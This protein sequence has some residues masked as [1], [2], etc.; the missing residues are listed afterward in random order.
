MEGA[1]EVRMEA[2]PVASLQTLEKQFMAQL[3]HK[4]AETWNY[5]GDPPDK[6]CAGCLHAIVWHRA[7][8]PLEH[9]ARLLLIRSLGRSWSFVP[10]PQLLGRAVGLL[11]RVQ[12]ATPG[13]LHLFT[14]VFAW[15]SPS[16]TV[17]SL[18][19]D[20]ALLHHGY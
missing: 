17:S 18:A 14:V 15:T 1:N 16:N 12:L 4:A 13:A 6:K 19:Q 5:P 10:L 11:E 7:T 20:P 2:T 3:Q 9:A 8:K